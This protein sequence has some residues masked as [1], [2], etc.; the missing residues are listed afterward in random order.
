MLII[1][2]DSALRD[3]P[4]GH[5]ARG[6]LGGRLRVPCRLSP[7]ADT[8]GTASS[9]RGRGVITDKD[10][11]G[12]CV[13]ALLFGLKPILSKSVL[14]VFRGVADKAPGRRRQVIILP[15]A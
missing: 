9:G 13:T 11:P 1:S 6:A 7:A 5:T 2:V 4:L 14:H 3:Q 8:P 10:E 15:L 12:F